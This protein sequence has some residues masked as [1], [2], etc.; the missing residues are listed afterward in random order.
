MNKRTEVNDH[1]ESGRKEDVGGMLFRAGE[2][3]MKGED[4]WKVRVDNGRCG[5]SWK[6]PVF[7]P[8]ALICD[9]RVRLEA[10]GEG[11]PDEGENELDGSRYESHG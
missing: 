8:H 11:V 9:S 4:I 3:G 1:D 2:I 7:I 5:W 6:S 10:L